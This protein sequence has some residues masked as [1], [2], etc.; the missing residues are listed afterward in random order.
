MKQKIFI[1]DLLEGA[2][3]DLRLK[4]IAGET[5]IEKEI[6]EAE[7]NRPGLSLTGFFDFF[8][9][10][11]IQIFG[12]G[13]TAYLKNFSEEKQRE[14]FDT[15]FSYDILCCIFTHSD[16]PSRLFLEYANR[17]GVPVL[18]TEHPTTRFVSMLT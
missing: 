2:E 12:K 11:R 18:F 7:I 14:I 3:A 15:F 8:A 5:G 4:L 6:P 17:N 16:H 10:D 1:R 9:F 13:E